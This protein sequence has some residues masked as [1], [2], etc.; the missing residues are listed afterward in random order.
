MS[1]GLQN[2]NHLLAVVQWISFGSLTTGNKMK[3]PTL[4]GN[5]VFLGSYLGKCF[6]LKKVYL[7]QEKERWSL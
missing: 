1:F 7:L 2:T 3:R 4:L 6:R 5:T